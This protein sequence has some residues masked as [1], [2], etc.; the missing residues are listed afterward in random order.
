[1]SIISMAILHRVV[2]LIVLVPSLLFVVSYFQTFISFLGPSVC[3]TAEASRATGWCRTS[4]AARFV[5]KIFPTRSSPKSTPKT[6]KSNLSPNPGFEENFGGFKFGARSFGQ[7][8][9]S[10]NPRK[11]RHD[12]QHNAIFFLYYIM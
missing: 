1:M 5:P 9:V 6:T 4:S 2:L 10:S 11:G 8:V 12:S 7:R 3:P